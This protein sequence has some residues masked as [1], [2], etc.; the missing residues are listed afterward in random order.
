NLRKIK[1]TMKAKDIVAN[2]YKSDVV[3]DTDA[4]DVLLHDDV[5]LEWHSTKGFLQLNKPIILD[6]S[7]E[8]NKAYVRSKNNISHLVAKGDT[9][10]VRYTQYV[11]TI[12][13]PREE[14]LLAHFIV[15]WELKDDK[16]F[17]GYQISQ[18]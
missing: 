15:I 12:E 2:F 14:M 13:N 4:L 9:V 1:K 5:L 8:L 3:L 7:K 17:R 10:T 6:L 18:L 11:K 16:L